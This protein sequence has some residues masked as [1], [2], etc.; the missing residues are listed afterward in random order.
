MARSTA[1]Q[2]TVHGQVQGVFFRAS[3]RR[4]AEEQ[5]VVGWVANREDGAVV[6]WL[7][8]D[9]DGVETVAA[10][11]VTG[12]PPSAEVA[13]TDVVEVEPRG[14]EGFEVRDDLDDDG[15]R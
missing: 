2:V 6:A 12:G 10:W 13:D 1:R 9:A 5:G 4:V 7:E 11:I 3:T 8:G 15:P 14:Y